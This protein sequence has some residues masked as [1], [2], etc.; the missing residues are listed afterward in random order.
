MA[1]DRL[2]QGAAKTVGLILVGLLVV[3]F[4]VWGIADIFTG[5]GQQT[6]IR[7]GDTEITAQDYARAS[8]DVLRS[9][10]QQAGRSLSLQ[11]ARAAGLDTRVLE[12]LI[13]GA[14]VDTHA[15]HLGLGISDDALLAQITKDPAFQDGAGNFSPLAFQAALRN[16]GMTEAGYLYSLREQNLRRQLLVTVGEVANSP[17]ALIDAMN[18]F[19]EERRILKYVLVPKSAAEE[20][21]APTEED[22]KAYYDNHHAKFTQPE[23]RKVGLIAVTPETVKD[24]LN[25]TEDDLK[26]E[27][28][29]KKDTL[30]APER[31]HVQQIALPDI[32]AA[33]KA[34]E[35]I[36]SGTDFV[37]MAKELGLTETDIDLGTVARKDLADPTIA[38][39][40]FKLEKDA[41]SEPIEGKLGGVVLI[42]VTEIEPGK[43]PSFEEAKEDLEK[44]ILKD[45]ASGAIFDMHDKVED[46]LAAGSTLEEA[47]GKLKLDYQVIDQVDREGRKPDG[48]TVTLPAQ[49]DLLNGIFATDAGIENDPI[50]ARDEGVIW[51]EVLGVTP[52]QLK[53]FDQVRDEVET[54]WRADETR[55]Q[56]AKLAQKFVSQLSS[57]SKTLEDVAKELDTEVLP[58]SA[59]KRDDIT[60]NVLP[61]AVSQAFALPK[62][63]F[64]S[65][66]SGV[67]EGRIVFRVDEIVEPPAVDERAINQL[68]SRIGLLLSEDTIAEY[69]SALESRYGVSVNQQALAKLVGSSEEP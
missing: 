8:R 56:V 34:H 13:G 24:Q 65:A 11:E 35:K 44:G 7:V 30:G 4:A 38:E 45:R 12:R 63:G 51:Y 23:Y 18:Q 59:L 28:E 37:E 21:S 67:D 32:G 61:P 20:V 69:F 55:N 60:V 36:T 53:P 31:R 17:R 40:A 1:L 54:D 2:R 14:A 42:R 5:Y 66:A 22:L 39:E 26:A 64:G 33:R 68:Q 43:I 46:E 50:D 3:S 6:L 41:V 9:M 47:A 16:I 10:S 15:T 25:I 27:Y 57:G 49:K 52:E 19:N 29:I 62:G 48:S 58:T